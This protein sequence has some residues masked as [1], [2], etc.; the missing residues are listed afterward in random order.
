MTIVH[1]VLLVFALCCF[2][3]VALKKTTSAMEVVALGLA[4]LAA[5]LI[6]W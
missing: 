1:L 4:L 6:S 3:L 5:S 2:L